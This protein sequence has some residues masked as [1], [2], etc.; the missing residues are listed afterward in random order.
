MA[1]LVDKEEK[2]KA[3]ALSCAELL[4]EKG[5]NSLTISQIAETAGVGKGTMYEYFKNKD[6]IVFEII[7]L[8]INEYTAKLQN[9]ISSQKSTKEQV[10]D[11]LFLIHAKENIGYLKIYLEF[12]A[13]SLQNGTDDMVNFSIEYKSRFILRLRKIIQHGIENGEIKP[14]ALGLEKAWITFSLGLIVETKT[15]NLTPAEDIKKALD[16]WFKLIEVN[17]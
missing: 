6:D 14:E 4:L 10:F 1:I 15:I 2:R 12:I 7:I 8:F 5:I 13:I 9:I 3:I 16:I 11:F 17:K